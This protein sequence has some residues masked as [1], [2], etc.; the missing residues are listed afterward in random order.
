MALN[1]CT[2]Y[3]GG[4]QVVAEHLTYPKNPTSCS[5]FEF[6]YKQSMIECLKGMINLM[7]GIAGLGEWSVVLTHSR[8]WG[9][10][11]PQ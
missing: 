1:L 6:L 10:K 11:N 3:A 8:N 4:S 2:P 9:L 5:R 7:I